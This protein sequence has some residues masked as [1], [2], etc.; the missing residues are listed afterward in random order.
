M[1]AVLPISWLG[2]AGKVH[3]ACAKFKTRARNTAL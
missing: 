3:M 1:K 2:Q